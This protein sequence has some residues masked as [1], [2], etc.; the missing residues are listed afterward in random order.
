[1][2]KFFLVCIMSVSL[3]FVISCGS[4]D[5]SCEQNEDCVS[6][7]ICDESLGKC[8]PENGGEPGPED[9]GKT[10][11]NSEG[12]TSEGENPDGAE[13]EIPKQQ[14]SV[15]TRFGN[16]LVP[17]AGNSF[18]AFSTGKVNVASSEDLSIDNAT[19]SGAP[20]DWFQANG[21]ESFPSSPWHATL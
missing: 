11:E 14:Y 4:D 17:K 12:G 5:D 2:K 9:E 6:G 20:A 7:Y 8:V 18:I 21:G 16:V 10:D 15:L 1:M 13:G 19:S 3:F